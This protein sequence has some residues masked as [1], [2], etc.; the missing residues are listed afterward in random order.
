VSANS[1]ILERVAIRLGKLKDEVVF[2]GGAVTELLVTDPGASEPRVTDDVDGIIEV[3]TRGAYYAFAEKLRAAG[4]SEDSSGTVICRWVVEGIKVDLMP[5][6]EQLLGFSNRWYGETVRTAAE[7][8]LPSG[9]PVRVATAPYF[10]A[11]KLEAFDGR[12]KGDF[13][14]SHDIEDF[15]AVVDGRPD[16][17]REVLE[18]GFDV[19]A[20]LAGRV[21]ALLGDEGFLDALPGHLPPDE[22]S[23]QRASIVL[24]RLRAL[25]GCAS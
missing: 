2:V 15:I 21:S 10:L 9:T 1:D 18:A 13:R 4:F 19:R 17:L 7:R 5:P 20:Y 22:V 11:T 14:A 25:G 8:V 24:D 16:L 3:T 23:Q 12:G 6:D